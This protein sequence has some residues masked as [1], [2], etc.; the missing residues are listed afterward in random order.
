MHNVQCIKTFKYYAIS[1]N[2]FDRL[3]G[4]QFEVQFLQGRVYRHG[5]IWYLLGLL[6]HLGL[7]S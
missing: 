4:I 5:V 3:Q 2:L 1:I 6:T 7:L